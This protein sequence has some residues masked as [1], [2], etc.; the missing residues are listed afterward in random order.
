M[1]A[2]LVCVLD[3]IYIGNYDAAI[4]DSVLKENKIEVIINCTKKQR[5]T[6]KDVKYYQIPVNDPPSQF[7]I[8][9]ICSNYS[10]IMRYM[11]QH[12][13]EGK[14]ILVHCEK[15]IQRSPTIVA[16]YLIWKYKVC[17]QAAVTFINQTKTNAFF[18]NV[19][20][21]PVLQYSGQCNVQQGATS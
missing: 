10:N 18:G 19:H 15:G 4:D 17:I 21:L 9:Y 12:V 7:D 11:D 14:N 2:D 16:M 20:F 8:E 5:R 1:V 3:G 13:T 6:K